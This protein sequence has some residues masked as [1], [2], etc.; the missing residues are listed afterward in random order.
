MQARRYS[1]LD[2]LFA[3]CRGAGRWGA[4]GTSLVSAAQL[5][6]GVSPDPEDTW[7]PSFVAEVWARIDAR[8]RRGRGW[9]GWLS[10]WAPSAAACTLGAAAIVGALLWMQTDREDEAAMRSSNYVEVLMLDS[11]DEHEGAVWM[12]AWSDE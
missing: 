8:R 3:V 4:H 6:A 5:W 12:A 1:A 7:S 2:G 10:R 9:V 11:L